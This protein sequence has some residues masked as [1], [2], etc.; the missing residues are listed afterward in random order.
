MNNNLSNSYLFFSEPLAPKSIGVPQYIF[1]DEIHFGMGTID[2]TTIF[3]DQGRNN[4]NF[5]PKWLPTIY[6]M[7]IAGS[8]VLGYTGTATVSQQ[9]GTT[10]GAGVFKSLTK[11]PE[12]KNTSV[13]AEISPIK[14]D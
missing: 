8:R 14:T 9:G 12:N 1:V 5:D 6:G 4:K 11:M 7:A 2:A 3:L 10:L 13:F